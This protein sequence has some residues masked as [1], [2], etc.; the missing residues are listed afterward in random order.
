MH[1][2]TLAVL[3][4][5]GAKLAM[6]QSIDPST[7]DS[8]T[9]RTLLSF[10]ATWKIG[11]DELCQMA[12]AECLFQKNGALTKRLPAPSCARKPPEPQL[13]PSRTLAMM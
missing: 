3:L 11:L 8:G 7:V 1:S 13:T 12:F 6:L 5:A 9:K 4:I 10:D 2:N